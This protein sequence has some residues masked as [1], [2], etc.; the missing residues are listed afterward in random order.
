MGSRIKNHR[1]LWPK[2]D[3]PLSPSV[4]RAEQSNTSVVFGDRF[5][6]KLYR[7]IED[8][9]NPDLEMGRFLTEA[10]FPGIPGGS[11]VPGIP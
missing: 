5:I 7:R 3:A 10:H 8:G 11:R 1:D 2:G 6:M 9:I 4:I